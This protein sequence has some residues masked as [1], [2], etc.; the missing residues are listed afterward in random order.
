MSTA[1]STS[2]F[3]ADA[4]RYAGDPLNPSAVG[5]YYAGSGQGG[6][7]GGI[8]NINGATNSAITFL[9]PLSTIAISSPNI[10]TI[11]LEATT[12][13]IGVTSITSSDNTVTVTP[14]A[15][16]AVDLTIPLGEP[17]YQVLT[18]ASTFING[19]AQGGVVQVPPTKVMEFSTIIGQNYTFGYN[20]GFCTNNASSPGGGSANSAAGVMQVQ[21]A[22]ATLPG[23]AGSNAAAI[24]Q[25]TTPITSIYSHVNAV[26]G[27]WYSGGAGIFTALSSYMTFQ[28]LPND[29]NI[30]AQDPPTGNLFSPS[31]LCVAGTLGA[32][33]F[34]ASYAYIQPLGQLL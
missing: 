29:P 11:V 32:P 1:Q 21:L 2:G 9:S 17:F 30:Q 20:F 13:T 7:S 25:N 10:S 27:L 4:T 15:G 23:A 16:G 12:S 18:L 31:T 8:T 6:T 22:G 34:N 28:V 14:G 33:S 26:G 24:R 19:Y 3:A 5:A